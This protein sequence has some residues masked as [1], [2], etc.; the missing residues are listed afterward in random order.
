MDHRTIGR[1]T[2]YQIEQ[3]LLALDNGAHA[4]TTDE[5]RYLCDE[6]RDRQLEAGPCV[7]RVA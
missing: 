1:L 3:R 2:S 6:L 4:D 5:Y 7:A